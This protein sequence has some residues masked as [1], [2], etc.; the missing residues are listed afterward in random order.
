[1]IGVDIVVVERIER[2]MQKHGAK[3][4]QRYLSEKE[5]ALVQSPQTAAGFWAAKEAVSKA[6]GTGIGEEVGFKDIT[7]SKDARGAPSF[8]LSEAVVR[9]FRIRATSLSIAHDGGFA[10]AVAAIESA[11]AD[12]V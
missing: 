12:E 11:P 1:M 6:L 10:I 9:K 5:A 3:F 4:L 2:S 7:L 8:T